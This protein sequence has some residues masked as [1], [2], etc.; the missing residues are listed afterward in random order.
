MNITVWPVICLMRTHAGHS[1]LEF[2]YMPPFRRAKTRESM[3]I[4]GDENKQEA[5]LNSRGLYDDTT[6]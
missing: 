1:W 2:H 6:K 5:G 3:Q 4:T